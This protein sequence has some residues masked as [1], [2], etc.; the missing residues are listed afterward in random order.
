M[1]LSIVMA[2][3][4]GQKYI[5][6]QLD[7]LRFQTRPA[8]EV[9]IV[10]DMSSDNTPVLV[11]DYIKNYRL[12]NWKF[13]LNEKNLGYKEN[14]RKCLKLST[15]DFIFLCDQDDIWDLDKLKVVEANLTNNPN[16]R[17]L[18]SAVHYVD[19]YDKLIPVKKRLY[20]SNNNIVKFHV[21]DGAIRQVPLNE[22]FVRNITPGCA[23]C[24]CREIANDFVKIYDAGMPHDWFINIYAAMKCNGTYYFNRALV[25]YRLHNNNT[26]GI[27]PNASVGADLNFDKKQALFNIQ[28]NFLENIKISTDIMTLQIAKTIEIINTRQCY[29][30]SPS[31]KLFIDILRHFNIYVHVYNFRQIIVDF[32][33]LIQHSEEA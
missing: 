21:R 30:H 3:Y 23:T 31:L 13:C 4:N 1:K 9:I 7:S 10:D 12:E 24:V 2:T 27:N 8:D 20:F 32:K 28:K 16:I 15:G 29:Y 19:E 5:K 22:L 25:N 11:S 14:F 6:K 17:V 26:I 33:Y 18:N